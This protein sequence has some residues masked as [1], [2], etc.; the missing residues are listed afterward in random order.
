MKKIM[1]SVVSVFFCS[2]VLFAME[3]RR[4]QDEPGD[5]RTAQ[6]STKKSKQDSSQTQPPVVANMESSVSNVSNASNSLSL[7]QQLFAFCAGRTVQPLV[8]LLN[9]GA[10]ANSMG[11]SGVTSLHAACELGDLPVVK[12]LLEK[13]ARVNQQIEDGATPLHHASFRGHVEVVQ[14]LLSIPGIDVNCRTEKGYIPLEAASFNGHE[15]VIRLLL[16]VPG[17]D[18]NSKDKNGETPLH[19]AAVRGHLPAV[20]LLVAQGADPLIKNN[21]SKTPEELARE[22]RRHEIAQYLKAVREACEKVSN[23]AQVGVSKESK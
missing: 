20:K 3:K 2:T 5:K 12:L 17:I 6:T 21:N 16:A 1:L 19:A 14:L 7:N 11:V 10:S 8:E 13:G 15:E 4:A 23:V 9:N 22:S 18:I